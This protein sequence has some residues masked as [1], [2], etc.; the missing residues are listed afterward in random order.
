MLKNE[1]LVAKIGLDTFCAK[2]LPP[3]LASESWSVSGIRHSMFSE[4]IP[5]YIPFVSHAFHLLAPFHLLASFIVHVQPEEILG[6]I[7]VVSM[8][9][10]CTQTV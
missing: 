3:S 1:Y 7:G 5:L 2:V 6:K 8:C 10:R 9:L 4:R